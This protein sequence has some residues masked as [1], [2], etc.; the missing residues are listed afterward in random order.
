[1]HHVKFLYTIHPSAITLNHWQVKWGMLWISLQRH[2]I[3][4]EWLIRQQVVRSRS[5]RFT[6][7]KN[8]RV[9]LKTLTTL[10]CFEDWVRRSPK[11]QVRSGVPSMQWL[12]P[13]KTAPRKNNQRSHGRGHLRLS[14]AHREWRLVHLIQFHRRATITQPAEE[15]TGVSGRKESDA[16][17]SS[18][19]FWTM[20]CWSLFTISTS[21]SV[22]IKR[23]GISTLYPNLGHFL[24][25]GPDEMI[26][27]VC[28][29][30]LEQTINIQTK[31]FPRS[32]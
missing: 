13:T 31:I 14:D 4:G 25:K 2:L 10:W 22:T 30:F 9:I 1:M 7:R 20:F 17:G 5:W 15:V 21:L 26:I 27:F 19:M 23:D 3:T 18:M 28:F 16:G 29:I 12:E 24:L 6:S 11:Q 8:G 32:R